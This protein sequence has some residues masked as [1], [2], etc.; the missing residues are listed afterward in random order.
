MISARRLAKR[1][2]RL[3]YTFS[4]VA[5]EG[6]RHDLEGISRFCFAASYAVAL[7][8]E[9]VALARP[10]P[11]L[12]LTGLAFGAAG[13]F[14][15]TAFLLYH[16]PTYAAAYGSL[17][18][19]AWV[20]AVFYLY[21]SLHH[22]HLAW[23]RVRPA[24]WSSDSL[25]WRVRSACLPDRTSR[26]VLVDRCGRALLGRRPRRPAAPGRRRRLRRL[27]RQRHVPRP[28]P[29]AAA[30]SAARRRLQLLS[31]ERLETM[32]RRAINLAFP[33]LT[34]GLL[35]GGGPACRTDAPP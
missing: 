20:L 27:P 12:R 4:E 18:L 29:P 1:K 30:R 19:L 13:L 2:R 16:R 28:G 34:A 11:L 17:L 8:L 5:G 26:A 23:G 32:N 22:R 3:L 24:A 14:A 33:L 35:V 15:H 21:G 6:G 10:R 7:G 25:A 31:L 9:L